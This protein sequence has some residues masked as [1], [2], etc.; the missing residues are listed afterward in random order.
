M[1]DSSYSINYKNIIY[2]IV[3][4]KSKISKFISTTKTTS[5]IKT[6]EIFCKNIY[7]DFSMLVSITF[8][9]DSKFTFNFW[10]EMFKLLDV[11]LSM[12]ST[13]YLESDEQLK[14]IM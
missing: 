12:T 4:H 3:D 14:R 13:K 5:A 6:A 9:K 10:I 11:K 8:D 7:K 2:M 1:T